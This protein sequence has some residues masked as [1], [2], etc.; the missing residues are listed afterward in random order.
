MQV[1]VRH[2]IA[3]LE[4]VKENLGDSTYEEYIEPTKTVIEFLNK[5]EIF[6]PDDTILTS[7]GGTY[8]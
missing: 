8:D 1:K 7:E 3:C 2:I 4:E 5:T 6:H